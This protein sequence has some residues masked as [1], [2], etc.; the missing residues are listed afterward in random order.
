[1]TGAGCSH[2]LRAYLLMHDK[3][4]FGKGRRED[5]EG[6]MRCNIFQ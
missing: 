1:V 6:C 3:E 4:E 5:K 2:I